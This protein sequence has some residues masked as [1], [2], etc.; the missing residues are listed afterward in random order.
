MALGG[1]QADGPVCVSRNCSGACLE[2]SRERAQGEDEKEESTP[3]IKWQRQSLQGGEL[4]PTH[5]SQLSC[6]SLTADARH[7]PTKNLE[8]QDRRLGQIRQ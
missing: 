3:N 4:L 5:S 6:F 7:D 2:V 1:F 8:V